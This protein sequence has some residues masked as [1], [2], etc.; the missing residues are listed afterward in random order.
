[1]TEQNVSSNAGLEREKTIDEATLRELLE[2]GRRKVNREYMRPEEDNNFKMLL[3]ELDYYLL[4]IC[5]R[6]SSDPAVISAA[7]HLTQKAFFS[8]ETYLGQRSKFFFWGRGKPWRNKTLRF[9]LFE[10]AK[11][12]TK[13]IAQDPKKAE[14]IK[15]FSPESKEALD[16]KREVFESASSLRY[17]VKCSCM[18]TRSTLTRHELRTGDCTGGC[19]LL[20]LWRENFAYRDLAKAISISKASLHSYTT[21]CLDNLIEEKQ[22]SSSSSPQ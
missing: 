13:E 16:M 5:V 15:E 11:R 3:R 22:T 18:L 2:F 7:M 17:R 10:T 12:I 9:W 4:Q 20:F 21:N 1:M 19:D 6:E 14:F 8:E